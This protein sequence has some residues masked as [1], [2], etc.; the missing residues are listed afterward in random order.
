MVAAGRLPGDLTKGNPVAEPLPSH[1]PPGSLRLPAP[2]IDRV[3]LATLVAWAL[4]VPAF[5]ASLMFVQFFFLK[6]ATDVLL[7]TPWVVGV[8]FAL[9]RLWDAFSDPIVG[10]WSDRTQTRLGRRRP[11]MFAA[12][13][14]LAL[15][16]LILWQ[17]PETFDGFALIAWEAVA[18]FF[19]YTAYTAY[20][21]PHQSLGVELSKS[22]HERSRVFGTQ[23]ACFTVGV[24][25]AFAAMQHVTVAE[26]PRAAMRTVLGIALVCLL[27]LLLVAPV[28]VRERAE[29]QGR[30]GQSSIG[31]LRDVGKNPYGRRLLFV[32]FV[33]MLGLGV[34]GTLSPYV[35]VYLI[36]RPDMIALLPG[37]FVLFNIASIPF[38]IWASKQW[39]KRDVWV[40][41]MCGGAL[42]FGAI[43]FVDG[44]G[45]VLITVSLVGAGFFLGCGGVIGPSLLADVIDSDELSTGERKEGT[46]AAAWGF[47][48]KASSAL[49]I[50]LT[51]AALQFSGFVPNEEQSPGALLALRL[52]YGVFPLVM[53]VSAAAVLRTFGLDEA[54]HARIRAAL[55]ARKS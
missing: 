14:A 38:W 4:P 7:M 6:Y 39:G 19:F 50:L 51:G 9:G 30:G 20:A 18:L 28:R 49:V 35:M 27:P 8:A 41:A 5:A 22:H 53:F 40:V 11:W 24:M 31:S 48:I 13:P 46:Y 36:K 12:I 42:C 3:P 10:T 26:D 55:D 2:Q 23:S 52:T 21:V 15:A 47:A 54:V 43:Y 33:Q 34:V 16:S 32:Q 37:V 25:L 44:T 1:P 45:L 17:P 29:Y